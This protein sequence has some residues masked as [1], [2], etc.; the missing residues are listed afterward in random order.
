M[1][2]SSGIKRQLASILAV[3]ISIASS[4]PG[5]EVLVGVLNY[6]N[7]ALGGTAVSHAVVAGT[8][9]K[10]KLVT[11][12]SILSLIAGLGAYIPSL[13]PFIEILQQV[14]GLLGAAGVS[15]AITKK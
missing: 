15:S 1:F 13:A 3:V 5:L 9:T 2:S 11:L 6:I 14:A 7:V 10:H 8:V 4:V 12:A